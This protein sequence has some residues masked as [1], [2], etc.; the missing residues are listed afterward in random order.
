MITS[1]MATLL[2]KI[3]SVDHPTYDERRPTNK[4]ISIS[5]MIRDG[6]TILPQRYTGHPLKD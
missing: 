6:L 3:K 5:S 4:K 1:T 2:V